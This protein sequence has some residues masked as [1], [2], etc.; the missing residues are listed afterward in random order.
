[1]RAPSRFSPLWGWD[2]DMEP[3]Y[4]QME[5]PCLTVDVWVE[6]EPRNPKPPF[7]FGFTSARVRGAG[8]D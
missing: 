2:D 5:P 3:S 7:P 1:M 6:D 8:S 4:R